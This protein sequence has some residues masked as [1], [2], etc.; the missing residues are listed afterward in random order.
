MPPNERGDRRR[1]GQRAIAGGRRVT[2]PPLTTRL[3]ADWMG[4]ETDYIVDAIKA[5]ELRAERFNRP[6]KR[7]QY[8]IHLNDFIAFLRLTKFQ[9]LPKPSEPLEPS[10]PL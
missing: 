1:P 6:G 8:R 5:G 7:A 9:R 2:D 4:V 10:E 3:A